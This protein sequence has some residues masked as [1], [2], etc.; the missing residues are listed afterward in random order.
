MC[1]NYFGKRDQQIFRYLKFVYRSLAKI[2]YV[3]LRN[4]CKAVGFFGGTN[5]DNRCFLLY[6]Y[7]SFKD[8]IFLDKK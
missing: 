7:Y 5:S 4:D 6:N 2:C 8:D 1:D 3:E